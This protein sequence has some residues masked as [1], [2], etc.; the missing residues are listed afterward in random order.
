[1]NPTPQETIRDIAPPVDF[2]PY[3]L[4]MLILAG[5][6]LAG[7]LALAAWL[8]VPLGEAAAWRREAGAAGGG[9]GGV[10]GGAAAD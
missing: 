4:W 5:V 2:F 6:L 7:L 1:M 10:G 3:P 9:A 8:I